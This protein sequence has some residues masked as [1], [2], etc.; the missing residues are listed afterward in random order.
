MKANTLAGKEFY[1]KQFN[2]QKRLAEARAACNRRRKLAAKKADREDPL[3]AEAERERNRWLYRQRRLH[4]A[5]QTSLA[6]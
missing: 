3:Y 2:D 5:P 6:A 1:R 4:A